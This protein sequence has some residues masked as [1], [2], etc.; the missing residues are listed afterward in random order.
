MTVN[1]IDKSLAFRVINEKDIEW[2]SA[3]E[4]PF[5]LHGINYSEKEGCYRRMNSE[6]AHDEGLNQGITY[7]STCTAGGRLRF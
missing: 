2:R 6:I 3:L 7:L 5:S 4:E 1:E